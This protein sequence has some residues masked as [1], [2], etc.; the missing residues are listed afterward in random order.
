MPQEHM[1]ELAPQVVATAWTI[2]KAL[3]A[4]ATIRA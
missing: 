1:D 2:S 3:G 4:D